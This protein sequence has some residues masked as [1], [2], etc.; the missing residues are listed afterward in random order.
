M[1]KSLKGKPVSYE[2]AIAELP[3]A[4][5]AM[6][7]HSAEYSTAYEQAVLE[8]RRLYAI[9][10]K[11]RARSIPAHR[12]YDAL[13]TVVDEGEPD[14]KRLIDSRLI[15]DPSVTAGLLEAVASGEVET[16]HEACKIHQ[17]TWCCWSAGW[18]G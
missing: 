14:T 16:K 9:M 10:A 8:L 2:Q 6:L 5:Q 11:D 1:S 15:D 4:E 7:D 12:R 3:A 17:S 13:R 18:L